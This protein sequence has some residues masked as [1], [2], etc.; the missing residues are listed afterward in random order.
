MRCS[1]PQPWSTLRLPGRAGRKSKGAVILQGYRFCSDSGDCGQIIHIFSRI[2]FLP[3]RE[4]DSWTREGAPRESLPRPHLTTSRPESLAREGGFPGA[5]RWTDAAPA[6][7]GGG[8]GPRRTPHTPPILQHHAGHMEHPHF[9]PPPV[10]LIFFNR[11][12]GKTV[13]SNT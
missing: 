6:P 8:A 3:G 7:G 11:G 10:S 5:G 2:N 13:L 1:S 12:L 9:I 4:R